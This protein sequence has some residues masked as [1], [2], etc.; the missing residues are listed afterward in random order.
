MTIHIL[1]TD[2]VS[3]TST[4]MSVCRCDKCPVT[5]Y[6]LVADIVSSTEMSR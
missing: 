5:V 4:V 3:V 6:I 1:A 2:M